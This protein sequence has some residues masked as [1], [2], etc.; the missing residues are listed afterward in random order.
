MDSGEHENGLLPVPVVEE[1]SGRLRH[2]KHDKNNKDGKH[3]LKSNW[4][5]PRKHAPDVTESKVPPVRERD[6][7]AD[8][9][10]LGGDEP[11][12]LLA[13]AQ[14]RLVH[15][16]GGGLEPRADAGDDSAD[17]EVSPV[18]GRGLEGG[19]DNDP[20]HGEPDG[21]AAAQGLADEEVAE[22]AN[23]AAEVVAG[24]D[25]AGQGVAGVLELAEPVFVFEDAAEYTLIITNTSSA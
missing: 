4:P 13:L 16:H 23:E 7:D 8:K 11:T 18:E 12:P 3:S 6:T 5:P 24:G 20:A 17:D 9:H 10:D 22:A 1:P 2:A 21:A 25:E 19:A 15:G 14:L